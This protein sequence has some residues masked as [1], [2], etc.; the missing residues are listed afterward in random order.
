MPIILAN[1]ARP[2]CGLSYGGCYDMCTPSHSPTA[3]ACTV[4]ESSVGPVSTVGGG[5]EPERKQ[6][7]ECVE[8]PFL[9]APVGW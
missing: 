5:R 9:C 4:T 8:K 3:P 1:P 7:D 6:L 2:D